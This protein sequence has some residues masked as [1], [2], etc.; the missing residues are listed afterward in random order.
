MKTAGTSYLEA[1]RVI[2]QV[3]PD[4][5]RKIYAISLDHYETDKQ[6]YHVSAQTARMP[7]LADL[8]DDQLP[9]LLD[10]FDARQALHVCFGTILDAHKAEIMA[11]LY[12]NHELYSEG[13]RRHFDKH[14]V[15]FVRP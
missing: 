14:L 9:A 1:I 5:F 4:L 6:S 13:L 15:D 7:K 2:A 10:H 8:S 3:D 12:R 11:D